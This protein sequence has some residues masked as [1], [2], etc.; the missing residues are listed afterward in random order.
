MDSP[1][2]SQVPYGAHDGTPRY[3]R[4][5][6]KRRK[7]SWPPTPNPIRWSVGSL[8]RAGRHFASPGR[9]NKPATS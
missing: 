2:M 6:E 8:R 3:G 7:G 1:A 9:L 5:A 4:R